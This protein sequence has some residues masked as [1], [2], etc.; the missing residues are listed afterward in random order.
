M[1]EQ[2]NPGA[3]FEPSN[4]PTAVRVTFAGVVEELES[5]KELASK[6]SEFAFSVTKKFQSEVNPNPIEAAISK[7]KEPETLPELL[8]TKI[9]HTAQYLKKIETFLGTINDLMG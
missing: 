5:L 8:S 2:Y 1:E 6:V 9:T 4:P 7:S 3:N